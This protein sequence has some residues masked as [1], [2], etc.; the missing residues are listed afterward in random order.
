MVL[1]VVL[2]SLAVFSWKLI[3]Y[4]IPDRLV[5]KKGRSIADRMTVTLLAALVVLQGFASQNALVLDARALSLATAAVLLAIRVPYIFV[6]LAG[7]V[8]AGVSRY[9]GF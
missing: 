9:L 5:G 3:G 1:T 7:A 2:G 4:L 8:V 6:V